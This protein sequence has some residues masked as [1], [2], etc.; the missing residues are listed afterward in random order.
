MDFATSSHAARWLFSAEQLFEIRESTNASSAAASACGQSKKSRTGEEGGEGDAAPDSAPST[1]AP[2]GGG[3][4]AGDE[5]RLLRF[6]DGEI[7]KLCVRLG[8]PAKVKATALM[9]C[10]RFFLHHSCITHNPARLMLTCIYLA[11]KIEE[12]YI[13]AEDFCRMLNQDIKAVLNNEVLLLQGLQFD[14][15]VHSPYRALG[16]LIEVWFVVLGF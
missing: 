12:A 4:S 14:L 2:E 16:G 5:R 1:S 10:K 9:Y 3:V 6:Y 7:V 11:G 8:Y 15:I 13:G